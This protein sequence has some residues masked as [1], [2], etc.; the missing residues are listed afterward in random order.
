[1]AGFKTIAD[2][3]AAL[4]GLAGRAILVRSDLNVP[5]ADGRVTDATRIDATAHTIRHLA[6]A[7]ARVVV[8]S[9]FGRPKGRDES[10]TLAGIAA[11]LAAALGRAVDFAGDCIGT[12]TAAQI[13]GLAPGGVLLLENLRFHAGEEKNDP[14]FVAALAAMADGYVND[15]F[16]T[17]HRS[18]ASTEGLAH[19]LPSAAG[20]SMQAELE[21]LNQA[22]ANPARPVAAVVGGAKVSSK[23]DVLGNLVGRV[24]ML[25]IGGGMA[26]TFLHAQGIEVG[27]SL[28]ERDLA[29]TARAIIAKAKAAGCEIVLPMDAIVASTLSAGIAVSTVAIDAV[30]A[31]QMILD[32]GP[33]TIAELERRFATCRTILWNGP[34]GAFEFTPFDAG[35]NAAARA[36]AR[37]TA[38]GTLLSVA[39]G[40]DTVAALNHAGAAD[41]FSYVSTAGGAFLEWLEGKTLPGVKA[42]EH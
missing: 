15:A 5:M 40:G 16:S 34:L 31:D 37:L 35:T 2:L 3:D 9:H 12:A 6:E 39:G 24:D 14:A 13:A 17:A 7:G 8:M 19:V 27:K 36:A 23:L 30:P 21:A 32:I 41:A 33:R 38:A 25:V 18:H 11:P 28:C 1:M 29:D 22:L 4:G 42:L 10:Q 20:L 26:N